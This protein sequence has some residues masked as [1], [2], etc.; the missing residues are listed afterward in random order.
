MTL[1]SNLSEAAFWHGRVCLEC[2][3]S[4]EEGEEECPDCGGEELADARAL[5]GWL[6]LIESEEEE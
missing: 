1:R 5:I 6:N 3:A 2:G 4:A